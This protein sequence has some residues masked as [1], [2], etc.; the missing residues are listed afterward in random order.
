MQPVAMQVSKLAALLEQAL[1][2]CEVQYVDFDECYYW[3]IELL[4]VIKPIHVKGQL[5]LFNV[6]DELIKPISKEEFSKEVAPL[7]YQPKRKNKRR[8]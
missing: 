8:R 5:K 7:I 6:A 4:D 2:T 3:N 1:D